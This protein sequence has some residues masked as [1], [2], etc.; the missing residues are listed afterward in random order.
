M[1]RR[2]GREK[3]FRTSCRV[4][5]NH[6]VDLAVVGGNP[7]PAVG[8]L[9]YVAQALDSAFE[10]TYRLDRLAALVPRVFTATTTLVLARTA[11]HG[12][13]PRQLRTTGVGRS[14]T[15]EPERERY[16]RRRSQYDPWQ[17]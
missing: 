17:S 10:Q 3:L 12:N 6:A 4:S 7:D 14:A 9:T 16:D 15:V 11:A 1:G 8:T 2:A 5:A 13:Y